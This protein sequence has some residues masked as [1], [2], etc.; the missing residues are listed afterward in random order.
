MR[1][2]GLCCRAVSVR[3]SVCLSV[4]FV[5][6]IQIAEDMVKLLFQLGSP[7]IL[8]FGLTRPYPIPRGTPSRGVKYTAMGKFCDLRLKSPFISETV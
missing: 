7:V 8:V 1:K 6:S 3:L 2:R 4:T 5:Y